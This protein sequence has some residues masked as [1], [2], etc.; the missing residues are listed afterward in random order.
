MRRLFARLTL[1]ASLCHAQESYDRL[2]ATVKLWNY[3]KYLHPHHVA[4]CSLECFREGG[5]Q[6]AGSEDR[7]GD[8]GSYGRDAGCAEGSCHPHRPAC[9]SKPTIL[10]D[11][12]CL[13]FTNHS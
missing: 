7:P 6:S 13:A 8:V 10:S 2:A 9:R 5:P 1:C 4:R 12:S 3:V 11:R